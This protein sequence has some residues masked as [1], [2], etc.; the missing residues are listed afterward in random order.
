[1]GKTR[2]TYAVDVNGVKRDLT[3]FEVAPGVR[4]A[5]LNI[6]GDVELTQAAARGLAEKLE[7]V[8]VDVLVTAEA[9]SIPLAYALAA[10]TDLPYVVLRKAY[11]PYMG[12]A[13]EAETHSITTG[14]SQTLYLDEKDRDLV[15]GARVA[16]VDDVISTGS[17]LQ[18]MCMI[19]EKAN[20]T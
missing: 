12:D 15:D 2:E 17:T 19:M 9:K 3:L 16:L 20:A 1:M 7:P 18:A 5:I 10:E 8:E 11:K 13:L 4:I 14:K 6:L